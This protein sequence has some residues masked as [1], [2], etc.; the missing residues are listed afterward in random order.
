MLVG[1]PSKAKRLLGWEPEVSFKGLIEMMVD[2]DLE[3]LQESPTQKRNPV[4]S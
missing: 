2:A 3:R 4:E 1:D